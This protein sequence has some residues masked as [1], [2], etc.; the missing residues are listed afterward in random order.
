VDRDRI[1]ELVDE[2][3]DDRS[4]EALERLLGSN[5][6]SVLAALIEAAGSIVDDDRSE[7]VD[8]TIVEEIQAHLVKCAKIGPLVDALQNRSPSVRELALA[9]LGEI[10]DM[11]AAQ[12]MIACLED[13]DPGVREAAGEHLPLLSD[14]DFGPDPAA[15]RKW[16]ETVAAREKE[17]VREERAELAEKRQR[18][19]KV[20]ADIEETGDDEA[21]D[22]RRLD[23]DDDE[24]P[25][26]G[27][28]D[29]DGSDGD[30]DD[31]RQVASVDRD[32]D[33]DED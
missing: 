29:D 23:G 11:G 15:W 7:E 8:D 17:R 24:R 10:G 14:Q 3:V 4:V 16:L 27:I 33:S 26:R 6:D 5:H 31:R 19:A 22:E 1:R 28:R 12:A 21:S 18:R 2:V 9:C 20:H 25:L 32:S 30:D 13:E